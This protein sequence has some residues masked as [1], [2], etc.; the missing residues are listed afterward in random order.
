MSRRGPNRGGGPG[1][2]ANHYGDVVSC[3]ATRL[4]VAA[5]AAYLLSGLVH[6][7]VVTW[8]VV[9]VSVIAVLAW[10]RRRGTG[11]RLGGQCGP[12]CVE[13]EK[14]GSSA[15]RPVPLLVDVPT[16]RTD[17]SFDPTEEQNR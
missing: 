2:G 6:D 4:M 10:S 1:E 16:G 11:G 13:R 15:H 8:V 3:L 14:S 7:Q 12:R 5:F 9:V 17:L